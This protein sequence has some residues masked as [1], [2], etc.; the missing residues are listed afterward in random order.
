MGSNPSY[1]L[2]INSKISVYNFAHLNRF[3]Y[4]HTSRV[5]AVQACG[6]EFANAQNGIL[7]LQE[8]RMAAAID[9]KIHKIRTGKI[10]REMAEAPVKYSVLSDEAEN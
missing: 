1:L 3:P 5:C 6:A 4:G 10:N 9:S 8:K 2:T 7:H